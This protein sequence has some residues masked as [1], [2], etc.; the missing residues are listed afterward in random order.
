MEK[1]ELKRWFGLIFFVIIVYWLI[2]NLALIGNILNK[3]IEIMFPFILGGALAFIL[4]IP[5]SFFENKL[6]KIKRGKKELIKNKKILRIISLIFAIIVIGFILFIIINLI[7][8]ELIDVIELLIGNV[9]YYAE[10]INKFVENN[11]EY[12]KEVDGLISNINFDKES[13]KNE[14]MV[15]ISGLLTS[16]ISIVVSI[17]GIIINLVISIVFSIYIL[18]SKEKLQIQCIKLLKAYLK[19]KTANK[20]IENAKTAS[21]IFRNFFTVQCLEA[22]ILGSLCIIGMLIFKIPYAIPIG[23]L[24]G[25]TAL[26]PVIGA[27]IGIIVGAVLIVSV[28]PVK[29][30]TFVIFVLVLQ[31]VEGNIIYPRVVGNSVG[32]PGM[33][34]LLAVTVGGSLFGFVG[35]LL[36]VPFVSVIYTIIKNDVNRRLKIV[37]KI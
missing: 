6:S 20:V 17:I 26:I 37:E 9:P 31:Q 2:N 14:L 35:M 36:G 25:V 34:V 27:F 12:L 18:T 7:L 10:E 33:W 11:T 24:V 5:M 23:I 30:I 16:S 28:N 21:K 15:A 19:E 3:I 22:T 13:I 1:K 32:L 4:N 29:V 8:P